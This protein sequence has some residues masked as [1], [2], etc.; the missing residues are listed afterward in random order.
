M[1]VERHHGSGYEYLYFRVHLIAVN[2]RL[3]RDGHEMDVCDYSTLIVAT[4]LLCRFLFLAEF[5]VNPGSILQ[6][7]HVSRFWRE[8]HAFRPNLT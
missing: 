7:Y 5:D 1:I 8:T 6:R 2:E 3:T 4:A